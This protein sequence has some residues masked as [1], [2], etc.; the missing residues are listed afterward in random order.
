MTVSARDKVAR[1][2]S[3]WIENT[4]MGAID[5]PEQSI[6]FAG[7]EALGQHMR[8]QLP[9]RAEY[10]HHM[11]SLR[12][13]CVE[14]D[15]RI[16]TANAR[17]FAQELESV[18]DRWIGAN[19][20]VNL[21]NIPASV[22]ID[23]CERFSCTQSND[24]VKLLKDVLLEK[25]IDDFV[26]D[27][28]EVVLKI[29]S[30]LGDCDAYSVSDG[31]SDESDESGDDDDGFAS[32]DDDDEDDEGGDDEDDDEDDDECGEEDDDECGEEDDD[33][34]ANDGDEANDPP[35]RVSVPK[36]ALES[37]DDDY[38]E[39]VALLRDSKKKR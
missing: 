24:H 13:M 20:R 12:L 4:T 26:H 35:P 5:R 27:A 16:Q 14:L 33:E 19:R 39:A 32:D 25:D 22:R 6:I 18:I 23:G 8:G 2:I 28:T 36:R 30:E 7:L 21:Y 3:T 17:D 11:D 15:I 9:P 29:E 1:A 31:R 38:E 34:D 10:S 37:E